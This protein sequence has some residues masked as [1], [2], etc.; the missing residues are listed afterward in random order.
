MI[1]PGLLV[2]GVAPKRPPGIAVMP[3]A[4]KKPPA[5]GVVVVDGAPKR[6]P[7]V[8]VD[9]DEEGGG[10]N[11]FPDVVVA[12]AVGGPNKA[13]AVAVAGTVPA[14]ALPDP[15]TPVVGLKGTKPLPPLVNA[16]DDGV[17]V[18]TI[19]PGTGALVVARLGA[20]LAAP[21][22]VVTMGVKAAAVATRAVVPVD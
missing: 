8:V 22:V 7:V 12:L 5:E 19:G 9:A 14:T 6:P 4:P 17:G 2:T 21:V 11:K 20:E 18:V 10:P 13:A 15:K 1:D 3:G 16:V